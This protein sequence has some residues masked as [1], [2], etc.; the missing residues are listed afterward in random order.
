MSGR[1]IAY[2]RTALTTDAANL[3]KSQIAC[4]FGRKVCRENISV[5]HARVPRFFVDLAVPHGSPDH[6]R[7]LCTLARVKLVTPSDSGAL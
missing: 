2:R 5:R 6:A 4:T 3:E 1:K 7:P